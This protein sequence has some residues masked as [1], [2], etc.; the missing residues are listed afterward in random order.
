MSAA[1]TAS[2]ISMGV[3]YI[4]YQ[5]GS[6]LFPHVTYPHGYSPTTGIVSTHLLQLIPNDISK[7]L[8]IYFRFK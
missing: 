6:L 4:F 5:I 2:H 7:V 3:D 8:N 1:L